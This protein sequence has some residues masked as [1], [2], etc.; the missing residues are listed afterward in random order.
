MKKRY[1]SRRL[2]VRAYRLVYVPHGE[3]SSRVCFGVDLVHAAWNLLR[4]FYAQKQI[5][6]I[7]CSSCVNDDLCG[8]LVYP[9]SCSV[10]G[11]MLR[12]GWHSC[13]SSALSSDHG[14]LAGSVVCSCDAMDVL[15]SASTE[16]L[17]LWWNDILFSER[18]LLQEGI[19]QYGW[20]DYKRYA[21]ASQIRLSMLLPE[22]TP[23]LLGFRRNLSKHGGDIMLRSDVSA[24]DEYDDVAGRARLLSLHGDNIDREVL[25]SVLSCC[26]PSVG[27]VSG[28]A[29]SALRD[30]AEAYG[31]DADRLGWLGLMSLWHCGPH[32]LTAEGC[33]HIDGLRFFSTGSMGD[34]DE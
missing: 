8:E 7:L 4:S 1:H 17:W 25:D 27:L 20:T 26:R 32:S 18:N 29:A 22:R 6:E 13:F 9:F 28:R 34:E 24:E 31:Y 11:D 33:G 14:R 12:Y 3:G 23:S 30:F 2:R 19:S 16:D 15:L 10:R 21:A 5:F